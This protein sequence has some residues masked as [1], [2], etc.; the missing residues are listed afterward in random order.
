[1]IP[2]KEEA[3]LK[4]PAP[5]SVILTSYN[6]LA[7]LATC[8][9]AFTRQSDPNFEIIIADDGSHQD[10]APLLEE[11]APRFAF[12]I[13]H[14]KHEDLGFRRARILNRAILSSSSDRLIFADVD[15]LPHARFVENHMRF[16]TPGVI[17]T[18]RRV[19]VS[20]DSVPSMEQILS[21]GLGYGPARLLGLWLRGKA[22]VVEHGVVTPLFY[23]S[24]FDGILG[25]NFS[26]CKPDLLAVNGFNEEFVGYGWEDTDLEFRL[27]LAGCRL[28]NLRNRVI[29]FHLLHAQRSEEN[30]GNREV[31]ERTKS[32]G[33][34][35]AAIG[36]GEVRRESY[37]V[38]RY[39]GGRV[40]GG[41]KQLFS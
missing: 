31:F 21:S 28:R 2:T 15:C 5:A 29:Q 18:G 24:S 39:P 1:M 37:E 34:A 9:A 8:F 22:R 35:R 26:A 11:W 19:H 23:E 3:R 36:L 20:R 33:S 32:S 12:G 10:Y 40:G 14:V 4:A 6:D 17:I 16:L 41:G 27:K 25:S 7:I 38:T 30:D 13:V